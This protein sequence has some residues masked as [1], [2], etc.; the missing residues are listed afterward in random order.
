MGRDDALEEVNGK[1]YHQRSISSRRTLHQRPYRILQAT[2]TFLALDAAADYEKVWQ[3]LK[4]TF[5]PDVAHC[6]LLLID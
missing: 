5:L 2:K 4:L 3:R 1:I 6:V